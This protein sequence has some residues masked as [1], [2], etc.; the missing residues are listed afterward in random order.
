MPPTHSKPFPD[1]AVFI[2]YSQDNYKFPARD[3]FWIQ[4]TSK[5]HPLNFIFSANDYAIAT[6]F[7]RFCRLLLAKLKLFVTIKTSSLHFDT[8]HLITPLLDQLVDM[9]LQ[10]KPHEVN[11]PPV[12]FDSVKY[13]RTNFQLP[14]VTKLDFHGMLNHYR[15]KLDQLCY[16]QD[17][18]TI[19]RKTNQLLSATD[20]NFC[21][22]TCFTRHFY[23]LK[24]SIQNRI[25]FS[26]EE[27]ETESFDF[28]L[29]SLSDRPLFSI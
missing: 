7:L 25:D 26:T 22:V 13:T 24:Q 12:F 14:S 19:Q 1:L 5:N 3:P 16:A 6:R 4:I 11:D 15:V 10:T 2:R 18:E 8:T 20:E 28:L 29:Q 21:M 27:L 17:L 23:T 9:C